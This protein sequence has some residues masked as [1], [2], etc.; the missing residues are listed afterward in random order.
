MKYLA[1]AMANISAVIDSEAFIIGG[2]VSNA[3]KFLIDII[4]EEYEK[5]AF[6]GNRGKK[7]LIAK[8]GEN[9]GIYGAAAKL[10]ELVD[11]D[12]LDYALYRRNL[13]S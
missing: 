7:I 13:K 8:L 6:K 5:A 11:G 12:S 9:A 4:K 1:K 3:G 10:L 2:G